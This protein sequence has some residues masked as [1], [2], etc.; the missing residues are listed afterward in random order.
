MPVAKSVAGSSRLW[1]VIQTGV[2]FAGLADA[3]S[4]DWVQPSLSS[5]PSEREGAAMAYDA[6]TQLMVLFGGGNGGISPVKYGDTWAF[7]PTSG[8]SQLSPAASPSARAGA[9]MAYDPT[10]GTEVL[11]GGS[12]YGGAV[13]D[14]T[15]TWD[16]TTW[17]EQFPPVSPPARGFNSEQMAYYP[18]TGTVVLFGG[19]GSNAALNDTWEW[20][21]RTMTWTQRFPAS[22]P[23]PRGTTI[24]YDSATKH[25]V[26]FGG[27]GGGGDC[28]R[29]YYGDTWNWNGITWTEQFPASAPSARTD[30]MLAYYPTIGEVV[31][32]GG[33]NDPGH[34]L[35]DTWTW[36]GITWSQLQTTYAPSGRWAASMAFYPNIK[37]LLLF[38]GE[39]T[40]DPFTNQTWLLVH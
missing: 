36:N 10:T 29:T 19:Y 1:T 14:D 25:I 40:G 21:G 11:F 31:M 17:T 33:F 28:C 38:G 16:G 5:L 22:S 2:L 3:Q 24:T 8:W 12:N 27:D 6:A 26:L 32:F 39:L 23:S 18:S 4:F 37:S 20:N 7:Y 35:S 30:L 9:S 15:W 34:G 13:L